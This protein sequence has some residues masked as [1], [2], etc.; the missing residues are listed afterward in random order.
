MYS[1]YICL[2]RYT[3]N[4]NLYGQQVYCGYMRMAS[5]THCGPAE[6]IS[7]TGGLVGPVLQEVA[8]PLPPDDISHYRGG[9]P[10]TST[11]QVP[12][13]SEGSVIGHTCLKSLTKGSL[14]IQTS[15]A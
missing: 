12:Q 8:V 3:Y 5:T 4:K 6:M 10:E 9:D 2:H 7:A 1:M 14:P 15:T 11:F 13:K